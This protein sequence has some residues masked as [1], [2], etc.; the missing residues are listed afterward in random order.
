MNY[1]HL[2]YY[3]HY[4]TFINETDHQNIIYLTADSPNT[5]DEL[6]DNKVHSHSNT[7]RILSEESLIKIGT[8]G[9][10]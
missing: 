10:I 6:Q 2:F 8:P 1:S 5:L 4:K 9:L 3:Q 7:R